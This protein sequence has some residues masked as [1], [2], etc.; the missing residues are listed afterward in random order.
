MRCQ[1]YPEKRC[2]EV[3]RETRAISRSQVS[4]RTVLGVGKDSRIHNQTSLWTVYDDTS[5]NSG[6]SLKPKNLQ[7]DD[8]RED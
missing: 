1:N 3:V 5:Y 6:V 7:L 8:M 2:E 4:S